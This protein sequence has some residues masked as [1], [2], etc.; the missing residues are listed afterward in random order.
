MTEEARRSSERLYA[1]GRW[2]HG[3]GLPPRHELGPLGWTAWRLMRRFAPRREAAW[4]VDV[5]GGEGYFAALWPGARRRL[6]VDV[7]VAALA[8]AKERGLG[9]VA[10]DAR[11]LPLKEGVADL[12]LCSDLLEHLAPEDVPPALAELAR[13]TRVGGVALVHTSSYGFY[14]RR[15][16]RR[17]PGREPLDADDLKDGHLNRLRPRELE[18]A[19][20][21]AGFKVKRRSYYKHF[22][23]P[24]TAIASRAVA[25]GGQAAPTAD[26]AV[27]LAKPAWRALNNARIALALLDTALFGWW[28]PGARWYID[29]RNDVANDGY[30]PRYGKRDAGGRFPGCRRAAGTR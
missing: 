3:R 29:W 23:Q 21:R 24:L 14:L 22:F 26:K 1:A 6:V 15:W 12:V 17:A 30:F 10:G 25:G 9:A 4:L 28:L 11:R 19:V 8:V 16:L 13:V 20:R 5:G 7:V 2:R 27:R 18:A